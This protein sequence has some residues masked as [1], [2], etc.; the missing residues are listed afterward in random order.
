MEVAIVGLGQMGAAMARR[1]ATEGHSLTVWNR[2]RSKA[3]G[4]LQDR[5]SIAI[6][7]AAAAKAGIIIS[8]VADDSAL[9]QVCHRPDGLLSA[10]P[11][12]LHISCSTVSTSLTERLALEHAAAGQ[13]F[14]SAQVLGR[15]DVAAAGHLS[16]I[17]A[18]DPAAL[19]LAQPI[20]DVL[21][22]KTFRMGPEPSMAAATKVAANFGI[23]AII[24]LVTEQI[25]IAG[26]SGVAPSAMIDFLVG[27]NFGS[28]MISVYGPMVA[29]KRFTPAAFPLKL[30][31][32]DVGLAIAAAKGLDLPLAVLLAERMD[33]IIANGGGDNDWS[34]LGQ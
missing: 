29:Q 7:P 9:E 21:G 19:D 25:R 11:N 26:A 3:E 20:F 4:L 5:V 28:R 22:S 16:I 33:A 23:A 10:G 32:K 27:T 24:Q 31:R 17:A 12:I 34:S 13:R 8:M 15:P 30:G 14:V 6:S 1:L 2:D 18:G